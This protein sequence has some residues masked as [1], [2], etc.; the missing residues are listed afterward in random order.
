MP[1]E[2]T[3]IGVMRPMLWPSLDEPQVAVGPAVMAVELARVGIAN[4]VTTPAVVMRDPLPVV[5]AN[6]RFWSGPRAM[7]PGALPSREAK[8]LDLA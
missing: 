8:F 2:T 1:A 4:S 6:Q 5:S 3:P 7:S